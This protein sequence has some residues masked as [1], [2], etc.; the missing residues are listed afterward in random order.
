MI[1]AKTKLL[2]KWISREK[3]TIYSIYALALIQGALYITVPL[4]I[5][6][7]ITYT[8][9]GRFSA[10]LVLLCIVTILV[11]VLIDILQVW[12]MR[13]NE[14]LQ[15]KI[16]CSLVLRIN[17]IASFNS[18]VKQRITHFFEVIVL[19]KGIGKILLEFSFS[20]IS[21]IFG[22]IIL[23]AYSNWFFIFSI[24]LAIMLYL[25][26]SFYGKQAQAF[27]FDASTYKYRIYQLLSS[28]EENESLVEE[29]LTN[30][31]DSRKNYYKTIEKQFK[32]IVFF[33]IIFI[34]VLLLLGAY[35][36][37]EGKLN[38]GQFVASEIIIFL[39]INSAE[40]LIGNLGVCYDIVTALYKIELLFQDKPENSFLNYEHQEHSAVVKR[41]NKYSGPKIIKWSVYTILIA[42]F[43]LLFMPWNQ[44]V[45]VSGKVS[46]LNPENKPQQITS[47]I[48][49]R[50]EKWYIQDGDFVRK[51]DTIA[52]IS[53]IKEEYLDSNL[54]GRTMSQVKAKEVS[55]KSYESKINAINE[56]IDALNSSLQI[57]TSQARNKIKQVKAKLTGDSAELSAATTNCR[58]F[59]DQLKRF[60]ELTAKGII[61]ATD[62]ENRKLKMQEA[63]A[64]RISAESKILAAKNELYNAELDLNSIVQEFNEKLMKAESDK[65]STLSLLYDAEG[66][67]NK[68]QI[69]L[70]NYSMRNGYYYILA[71]QNGYI[72]NVIIKGVGEILKEGGVLC[73]IVP[74]QKEQAVEL[75]VDPIDL[76][77][78]EKGQP[79]Q[80]IFDGWPAFVF[81]GW[82]GVSYGSF[83][84]EIVN[85]DKVISEN[86]KFRVLAVNV[87]AP[88]PTSIQLGGGV[89]GFALLNKVPV[90]YEIWRKVNGF[91][92]EFYKN[93]KKA[94]EHE[95]GKK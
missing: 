54:V 26:I 66:S 65:F 12:K 36:V 59:E 10:S 4:S 91:P 3:P 74:H 62:L 68:L 58:I 5:Q 94:V 80:L 86:G 67:L 82:P 1:S 56:Q 20:I 95:Y 27:N 60:E 30:F 8:M 9:A 14:T 88:W 37:Q 70:S 19:K 57:K 32:G 33:K 84:A 34:S 46:V 38:I 50:I 22:I 64:K 45:D 25:I 72:H 35:L 49:G 41:I 24:G 71:P 17:A 89:K 7:I 23:P 77:L 81:S 43:V 47:R 73:S 75:F 44:S 93:Q 42:L 83:T 52:F 92:P 40:K 76:P 85:F 16:F 21:I 87:G 79:V 13:L 78:V 39:V 63:C 6:G 28:D 31:L 48:A 2:F 69:Q 53:E 29:E 15:E 90:I 55:M 18:K 11:T 61:S 51:N